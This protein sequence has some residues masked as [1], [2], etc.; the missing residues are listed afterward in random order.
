MP[1]IRKAVAA[2]FGAL[3]TALVAAV[4]QQG[5]VPGWPAV[6]TALAVAASA[7]WAVWRVPNAGPKPPAG[8]TGPYV[9]R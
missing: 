3:V 7:G 2:F 5:G 8:V 9:A 6:L 1:R 4:V